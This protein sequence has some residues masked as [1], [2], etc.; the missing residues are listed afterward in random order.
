[1]N[2]GLWRMA[3]PILIATLL[4][5]VVPPIAADCGAEVTCMGCLE[6]YENSCYWNI[7]TSSCYLVA[8][9]SHLTELR[10]ANGT[11]LL[12]WETCPEVQCSLNDISFSSYSCTMAGKVSGAYVS[13]RN[14]LFW[15]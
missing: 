14:I 8:T 10:L 1:M 6:F 15:T 13:D 4:L 9:E 3:I 7:T 11:V 2:H 12:D 5:A